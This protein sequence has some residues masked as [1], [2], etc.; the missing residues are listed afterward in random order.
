MDKVNTGTE[1]PGGISCFIEE[2]MMMKVFRQTG[3]QKQKQGSRWND[4]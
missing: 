4:K 2:M 1:E 3:R